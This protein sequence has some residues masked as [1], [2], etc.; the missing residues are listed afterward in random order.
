MAKKDCD[1]LAKFV[2]DHVGGTENVVSLRHCVTRLR[3]KLKDESR[4]DTE[5]LKNHEWIIDVIQ[6]GGQYQV[7]IGNDVEDAFDA[8][9]RLGKFAGAAEEV[10]GDA[11]EGGSLFDRLVDLISS[12]FVPILPLLAGS[13]VIKGIVAFV[14]ALGW[15]STDSGTYQVLF[16]IG[17]AFFYFF[18]LFVGYTAAE[19]FGLNKFIGMA[20]GASLVSPVFATLQSGDPLFTL[21]EGTPIATDVTTT[22]FGIPL[23]LVTYTSSVMP[24]IAACYLGSKVEKCFKRIVPDVVRMFLVPS[25]TLVVTVVVTLL[26]VG[27]IVT[28]LSQLVATGIM[29][30]RSISPVV[31][32]MLVGGFWQVLVVFGLHHA[33]TPIQLNNL[34]TQ[35]FENVIDCMQCVPFTTMAVVLAVYLRTRDKRLKAIALPAAISSF[36]GVSEP[37]IYGVTLPLKR[38][39]F[40]TLICASIGGGIMGFFNVALYTQPGGGLFAIPA[41]INPDGGPLDMTFYGLLIALVVSMSLGFILTFFFGVPKNIAAPGK[42]KA[43]SDADAYD[44][45]KQEVFVA[46]VAGDVVALEDCDDEVFASGSVGKGVAVKP[47]E[48]TIVAPAD[49]EVTMLFKTGHAV[50]IT[51][52]SGAE[53]LIHIGIDTVQLDGRGFEAQVKMGDSVKQGQ[54]LVTFDRDV[55]SSEGYDDTVIFLVSNS[56][57]FQDVVRSQ[58]TT[59]ATDRELLAVLV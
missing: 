16:A 36:F 58:V 35:G 28:W 34:A 2:L 46:P 15:L 44:G 3:F 32:G 52:A 12:I 45:I 54:P 21:F 31:T 27:P 25:L 26:A 6:K 30:V 1:A 42:S 33:F 14:A 41:Y 59:A 10:D 47:S 43:A 53:L 20:I 40:F 7:V 22:L 55:L 37:S 56:A 49:G 8:V 9:M 5:A 18:P 17:N 11:N 38:P 50:G 24:T 23:L 29:A 57:S 51:T 39:F 4:A 19:K 13:G 48:G